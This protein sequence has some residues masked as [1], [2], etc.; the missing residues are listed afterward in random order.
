MIF[1][2]S[3]GIGGANKKEAVDLISAI[4]N[5][6]EDG[7]DKKDIKYITRHEITA[8]ARE[9]LFLFSKDKYNLLR[10]EEILKK[11][12]VFRDQFP[13]IY[14]LLGEVKMLQ[15]DFI[16]G[17]G[18][19]AKFLEI[20]PKTARNRANFHK[21]LGQSYFLVGEKIKAAEEFK[22]SID[23]AYY[24]GKSGEESLSTDSRI[25]QD[26]EMFWENTAVFFCKD[27][28]DKK[29]CFEIYEKTIRSF[30]Q[31]GQAIKSRFELL[32]NQ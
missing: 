14:K 24:G 3:S 25:S 32:K 6:L 5:N 19:Y 8:R 13:R 23:Q 31:Y 30:P 1:Y 22:K 21:F 17:E 27:L 15:G 29:T 7:L 12:L 28:A 26:E 4:N 9:V 20:S 18:Y 10:A 16:A 11:S 2:S